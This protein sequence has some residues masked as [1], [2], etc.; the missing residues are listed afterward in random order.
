MGDDDPVSTDDIGELPE[1][2]TD[3]I[4]R[5]P[6]G[7][8]ATILKSDTGAAS[9]LG[10]SPDTELLDDHVGTDDVAEPVTADQPLSAQT[11]EEDV[12]DAI[13]EPEQPESDEQ[14][15]DNTGGEE[16]PSG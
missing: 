2:K 5:A 3:D 14:A 13:Q 9:I 10:E 7:A 6:G 11:D 4:D 1:A 8:D 12:P 16:A 15:T